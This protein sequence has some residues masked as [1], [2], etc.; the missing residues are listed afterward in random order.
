MHKEKALQSLEQ[1]LARNPK[2]KDLSN[3][4]GFKVNEGWMDN[5]SGMSLKS[6]YER[7][8]FVA[9]TF[10]EAARLEPNDI[11]ADVQIILG[12]LYNISMDYD[13]AIECFRAALYKKPNDYTLWN[14]LGRNKKNFCCFFFNH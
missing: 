5:Y 13:K 1:W 9:N 12:L 11:D 4:F 7:H 14:K 8:D 2:Y 10:I 3:K 6:M